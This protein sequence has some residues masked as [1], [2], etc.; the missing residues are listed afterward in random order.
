[1]RMQVVEGGVHCR[2]A[3][4]SF[5]LGRWDGGGWPTGAYRGLG[6]MDDQ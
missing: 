6:D 3:R 5:D 1:M 2:L 4:I